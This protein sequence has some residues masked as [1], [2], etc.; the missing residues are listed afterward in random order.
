MHRS[1]RQQTS[2]DKCVML[3]QQHFGSSNP[4]TTI[5]P[6]AAFEKYITFQPRQ[7]S[8]NTSDEHKTCVHCYGLTEIGWDW[9]E[10]IINGIYDMLTLR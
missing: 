5:N 2:V 1:H 7:G 3:P 4:G 8:I 9:F 10:S 6:W